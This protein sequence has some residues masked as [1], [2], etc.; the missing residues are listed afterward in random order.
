MLSL[1]KHVEPTI[2]D[3]L[4]HIEK[5]ADEYKDQGSLFEHD[6]DGESQKMFMECRYM[7]IHYFMIAREVRRFIDEESKRVPSV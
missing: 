4:K 7:H 2:L 6:P 1:D 3:F 5:L